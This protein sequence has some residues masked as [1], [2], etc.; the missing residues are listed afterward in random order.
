MIKRWQGTLVHLHRMN[1]ALAIVYKTFSHLPNSNVIS[2]HC[3][4]SMVIQSVFTVCILY[5]CVKE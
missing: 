3:N 5:V 1:M 4:T 2:Q